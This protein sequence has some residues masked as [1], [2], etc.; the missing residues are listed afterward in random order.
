MSKATHFSTSFKHFVHSVEGTTM[1]SDLPQYDPGS[2]ASQQGD[3]GLS[4]CLF[5]S[6]FLDCK[7][8]II[9][10]TLQAACEGP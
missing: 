1:E 8:Q 3:L 6:P 5:N 7:V 4:P 2:A 10:P 9:R